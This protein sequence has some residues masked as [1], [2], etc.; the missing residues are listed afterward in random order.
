MVA[1]PLRNAQNVVLI[2][3]LATVLCTLGGAW[4]AAKSKNGMVWLFLVG[5]ASCG[6]STVVALILLPM[7]P[8]LAPIGMLPAR[9]ASGA[10]TGFHGLALL[11]AVLCLVVAIG[12]V[13][14][15]AGTLDQVDWG[16]R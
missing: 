16:A 6:I 11:D 13:R 10:G 15:W 2:L 9:A 12:A 7:V 1:D 14:T 5:T 3:V 4:F 8:R